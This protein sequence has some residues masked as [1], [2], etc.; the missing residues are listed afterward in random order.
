MDRIF[1]FYVRSPQ[2]PIL[3]IT[4]SGIFLSFQ[5]DVEVAET[6]IRREWPHIAIDLDKAGQVIA[7]EMVPKPNQFSIA[8]ILAQAGITL[9]AELPVDR[10]EIRPEVKAALAQSF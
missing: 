8:G 10:I 4:D 5:Q 2:P 3:E 9:P 6:V 1:K 7:I